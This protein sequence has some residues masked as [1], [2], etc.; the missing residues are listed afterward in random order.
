MDVAS[1]IE[2]AA[3]RRVLVVGAVPPAGRDWDLLIDERDGDAVNQALSAEGFVAIGERWVRPANDRPDVVELLRGADWGIPAGELERLFA[4]AV[5]LDGHDRLCVPSPADRLLILAR[6]LPRTPG[7]LEPKHRDRIGTTLGQDPAA[8]ERARERAP[9]WGL[10]NR[11]R[12]LEGR[13]SRPA[14]E[15]MLRPFLRRPRRGAIIALSGLDGVGK[16]T[17]TQALRE[18]LEALGYGSEVVWTPIGQSD[19]LRRFARTVKHAL[20]R[21]PVGPLAGARGEAA[22]S[23]ILSRTEPGTPEFGP[24]RRLAS[25][26]W[27]TVT[28]V[29]NAT[30]FRRAARGTRVRGRIVIFDRYVLDTVVDLRFRY[31]PQGRLRFQEALVRGLS[32]RAD[33]AYLLDLSPEVAHRRKPDWSLDQTRLRAGLYDRAHTELGVHRLD[34][35]GSAEIISQEVLRD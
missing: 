12:R 4:D 29:A 19:A 7:F 2:S 3:T 18:S 14:R 34:A 10:A 15:R 5:P 22:E 25:H 24:I 17:Q 21:L 32:P 13:Y 11:L 26:G 16:S 6:K 23:H 28:T 27:A 31:A 35:S 8:F 20:S 1:I 30:A 33:R 9:G